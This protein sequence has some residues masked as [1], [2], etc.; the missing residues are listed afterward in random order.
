MVFRKLEKFFSVSV[1]FSLAFLFTVA[2]A[3]EIIA[4]N[5]TIVNLPD[6]VWTALVTGSVAG[7]TSYG[8][9]KI[10]L[11]WIFERLDQNTKAIE[12]VE[13]RVNSIT[14]HA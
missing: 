11:D 1:V 13:Q 9:L 7:A 2:G 4:P 10:K 6:W 3:N 12:A 5:N 14:D 8:M